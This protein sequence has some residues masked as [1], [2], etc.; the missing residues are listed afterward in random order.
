ML[1]TLAN[2]GFMP[3]DG[4][5]ISKKLAVDVLSTVL[6]WNETAVNDLYDFAQRTNPNGTSFDLNHLTTH[7]ILEHDASLR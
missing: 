6:N 7:N 1:N 3:R 5:N 4:K 2:H